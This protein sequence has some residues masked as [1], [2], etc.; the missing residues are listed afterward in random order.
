MQ[1]H[2]KAAISILAAQVQ[3]RTRVQHL[4][5]LNRFHHQRVVSW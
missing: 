3:H 1:R 2:T 5:V 4:P